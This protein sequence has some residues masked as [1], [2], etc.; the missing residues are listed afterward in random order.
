MPH[1]DQPATPASAFST[2]FGTSPHLLRHTGFEPLEWTGDGK[3][4]KY[5]RWCTNLSGNLT[6]RARRVADAI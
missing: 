3:F 2:E 6:V 1:N 5:R 4:A